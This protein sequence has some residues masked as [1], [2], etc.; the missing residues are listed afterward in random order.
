MLARINNR[1]NRWVKE[2]ELFR[3]MAWFTV[4]Y[5]SAYIIGEG[6]ER[7]LERFSFSEN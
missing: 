1:I 6:L 3:A 2:S 7:Y 5:I 4:G